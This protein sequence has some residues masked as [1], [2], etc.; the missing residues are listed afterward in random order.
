M[1]KKIEQKLALLGK[2]FRFNCEIGN[3]DRCI[4]KYQFKLKIIEQ[5]KLEI[6]FTSIL[7]LPL[8]VYRQIT[9]ITGHIT[10][11]DIRLYLTSWLINKHDS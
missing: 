5:E 9:Q 8:V 10:I 7:P 4:N 1:T 11:F 2:E 3:I 6:N